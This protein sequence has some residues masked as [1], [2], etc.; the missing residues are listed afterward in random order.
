MKKRI[1]PAEADAHY[2]ADENGKSYIPI[3]LNLCFFRN[4]EGLPDAEAM[5]HYAAWLRDFAEN[6]GNYIRIWLGVPL[7][8]VMPDRIGEFRPDKAANIHSVVRQAE[9]LGLRIKFTLEHFRRVDSGKTDAESFPG[10]VDFNK[11]LYAPLAG[12][13]AEYLTSEPCRRAYLEKARFLAGLGLGDSPAVVA[14]ELWNEINCIGPVELVGPWS[15]FMIA[16]LQ[17]I[18]PRQMIVQNLGSFSGAENYRDYDYLGTVRGNAFLQAHRYL[19]PGAELDVCRGPVDL[20]CA[21][22][23]RELR[24]R[25]SD[26]PAILAESGAVEANHRCY[27]SLYEAD[28]EGTILH[29]VLF[30]P[31]FAGS[32]GCG[33]CWHWDH[34][35][36]SRHHLWHHFRRFAAA[37]EGIDPVAERFVPFYTET[38]RLRIYGL[39]GK[40]QNLLWCRDKNNSWERELR[41]RI[42]PETIAGEKIPVESDGEC[43]C[44]LPW[45]DRLETVPAT[46]GHCK[47]PAF[48]RSI[49]IRSRKENPR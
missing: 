34:I 30:A 44:Y 7:F 24:S 47:L 31:F 37:V 26:C 9:G 38:H 25:R 33:Q 35:Y 39:R 21:D 8:D 3:G 2:F 27:S 22:A 14:W 18:F 46:G 13:M 15:D 10:A 49:V 17:K 32:A 20:L 23:I 16:E 45:E 41:D 11:P 12:S 5:K 29:D 48:K 28:S 4:T 42:P 6:G 36:I 1:S 40:T 19:D 43:R